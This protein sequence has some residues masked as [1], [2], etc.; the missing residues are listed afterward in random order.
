M[1][2]QLNQTEDRAHLSMPHQSS[3]PASVCRVTL[4]GRYRRLV[5]R[6]KADWA[7]TRLRHKAFWPATPHDDVGF[8]GTLPL[9]P[10][11]RTR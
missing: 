8:C 5:R 9:R 7:I 2:R 4:I 1:L 11:G 6:T 3:D 10:C